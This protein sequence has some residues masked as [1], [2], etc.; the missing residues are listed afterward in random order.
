MIIQSIRSKS[1]IDHWNHLQPTFYVAPSY[2][3]V[4]HSFVQSRHTLSKCKYL[5][6][7]IYVPSK[8]FGL[9]AFV[10]DKY[11]KQPVV[12]KSNDAWRYDCRNKTEPRNVAAPFLYIFLSISHQS[13]RKEIYLDRK[14]KWLQ[15]FEIK[16]NAES[17]ASIGIRKRK[18][19]LCNSILH[20]I[21]CSCLCP[22]RSLFMFRYFLQASGFFLLQR[23]CWTITSIETIFVWFNRQIF[24]F[25]Y[26]IPFFFLLFFQ[27]Q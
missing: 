19:T 15:A 8:T 1:G 9:P 16:L 5:C 4:W 23:D 2:Y 21:A 18:Y 11:Q 27:N 24:P 3:L 22:F 17:L 14:R 25:S 20:S 7:H 12:G 10:C 13:S 26:Y 6:I